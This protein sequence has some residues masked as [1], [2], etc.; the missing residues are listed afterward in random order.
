MSFTAFTSVD[1]ALTA[2]GSTQ[3][4]AA[5]VQCGFSIATAASVDGTTGIKLPEWAGAGKT[6]IVKNADGAAA[7]KIYSAKS[8][9]YINGTG[10]S[11]A[12]SLA[13]TKSALFVCVGSDTWHAVLLD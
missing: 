13:A 7:C 8:T 4:D 5:A 2:T 11:T 12:Y 10:G 9:G 3:A 1:T 6:F